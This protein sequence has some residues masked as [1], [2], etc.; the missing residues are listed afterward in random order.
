VEL[1]VRILTWRGWAA[2]ILV[3][4]LAATLTF[5]GLFQIKHWL[6]DEQQLHEIVG[7][8]QSGRIVVAPP[9]PVAPP[10]K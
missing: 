4:S 9:A 5:L 8:I 1:Q 7:L 2:V 10:P 3:G 6:T